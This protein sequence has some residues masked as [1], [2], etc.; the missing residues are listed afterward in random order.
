MVAKSSPAAASFSGP[1]GKWLLANQTDGDKLDCQS[2]WRIRIR[3]RAA[4]LAFGVGLNL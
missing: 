3:L 4:D 2:V 1:Q